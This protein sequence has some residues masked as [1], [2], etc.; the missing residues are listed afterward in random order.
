MND[1]RTLN[2]TVFMNSTAENCRIL[3]KGKYINNNTRET[4]LNNNDLVIGVSGAGKT[5]GYVMPNVLQG[6]ESMIV[7]DTKNQLCKTMSEQ[8]KEKGYEI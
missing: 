3:A 2:N 7:V 5:R 8:L 6:N 4:G 1:N